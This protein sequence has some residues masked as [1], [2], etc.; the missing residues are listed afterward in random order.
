ML[1]KKRPENRC[2]F[3]AV[4]LC[5][6]A[7]S[8]LDRRADICYHRIRNKLRISRLRGDFEQLLL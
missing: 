4:W 8:P 6:G 2:G 5:A 7:V 3:P 1:R